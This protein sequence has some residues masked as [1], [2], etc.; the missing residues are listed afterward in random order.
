MPTTSAVADIAGRYHE[1]G[2]LPP[3][4]VIDEAAAGSLR[5]DYEDAEGSLADDPAKLKMMPQCPH[6]VLPAFDELLCA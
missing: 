6:L 5:A 2:Y 4:R 3:H 1:Q